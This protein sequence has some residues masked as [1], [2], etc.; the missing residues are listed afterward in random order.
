MLDSVP[1]CQGFDSRQFDNCLIRDRD[2]ALGIV[3]LRL[4]IVVGAIP[5]RP[6][7]IRCI[8]AYHVRQ[9][10]RP[11]GGIAVGG[12]RRYVLWAEP[13]RRDVR[14]CG[15]ARSVT[16]CGAT[17]VMLL[18]LAAVVRSGACHRAHCGCRSR[19]GQV[20]CAQPPYAVAAT[21]AACK[22]RRPAVVSLWL[23]GPVGDNTAT[24]R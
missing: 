2:A 12:A 16:G 10:W 1:C 7:T 23:A 11:N 3:G 15:A 9:D 14:R 13:R 5:R 24:T 8:A 17:R 22:T 6:Q 18:A 20:S 4:V 21:A 19:P